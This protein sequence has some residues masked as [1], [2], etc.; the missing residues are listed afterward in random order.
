VVLFDVLT[1]YAATHRFNLTE[2]TSWSRDELARRGSPVGRQ[3]IGFVVRGA[4][5]G[6]VRLDSDPP[7]SA[8][9]VAGGFFRALVERA[10]AAGLDLDHDERAE[11]AAWL[12][13][14]PPPAPE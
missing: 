7:P 12:G 11:L 14:G 3:S 13:I 10:G 5:Y 1:G 8:E 9:R 4:M 2:A 6:G